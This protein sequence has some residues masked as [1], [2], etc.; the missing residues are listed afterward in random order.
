MNWHTV[1]WYCSY[2]L[3]LA[4]ALGGQVTDTFSKELLKGLAWIESRAISHLRKFDDVPE[5]WNSLPAMTSSNGNDFHVIG[6]LWR[7]SIRHRW[8]PFTKCEWCWAL[9]F[10]LL[11][12]WISWWKTVE[13]PWRS[14]DVTLI[15]RRFNHASIYLLTGLLCIN[16]GLTLT[17]ILPL[18]AMPWWCVHTAVDM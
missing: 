3:Q 9:G 10:L 11:L 16:S 7:E 1:K 4:D 6:S 5:V 14:S 18:S 17:K 2:L 8:I 15:C 13:M 12:I